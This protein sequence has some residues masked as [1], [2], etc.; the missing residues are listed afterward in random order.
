MRIAPSQFGLRSLSWAAFGFLA[1]FF[2]VASTAD[3]ADGLAPPLVAAAN[4]APAA[5]PQTIPVPPTPI[6]VSTPAPVAEPVA[7]DKGEKGGKGLTNAEDK[8]TDSVR[9]FAKHM[10]TTD[11]VTL[12]DLN[13]AR[14]A[15]A[16]ID[17]LIDIEKRLNELEKLRNEREGGRFSPMPASSLMPPSP[18]VSAPVVAQPVSFQPAMMSSSSVE[19][20]RISGGAGHYTALLKTPDGQTKTVEVGDSFGGGK[21]I[22]ITSAGVDI[23][24]GNKTRLIPVKNVETVFHAP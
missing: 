24:Q 7:E 6:S 10:G 5:Q 1:G 17:A 4:A 16:K 18:I 20:S 15:I 9:G 12:E 21:V 22:A 8:I 3:A 2:I 11:A 23:K 19:V 14:Q 13:S